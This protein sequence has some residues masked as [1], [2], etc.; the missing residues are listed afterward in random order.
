VVEQLAAGIPTVAYDAPGAR[1]TL[2]VVDRSLLTP[3]GDPA[4]IAERALAVLHAGAEE[5]ST[6]SARCAGAAQRWSV[7]TLTSVTL[8][9]YSERLAALR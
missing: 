6:L 1:Q 7:D 4:A 8:D 3:L 5:Y 9:A 2:G